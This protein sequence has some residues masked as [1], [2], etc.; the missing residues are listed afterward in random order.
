MIV[1]KYLVNYSSEF[2]TQKMPHISNLVQNLTK[3]S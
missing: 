3:L 2:D 1:M